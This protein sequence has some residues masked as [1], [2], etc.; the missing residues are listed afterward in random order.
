MTKAKPK[1][2]TT[3]KTKAKPKSKRPTRTRLNQTIIPPSNRLVRADITPEMRQ[4][5]FEL[6]SND[7]SLRAMAQELGTNKVSL[8]DWFG[9]E[10]EAGYKEVMA[11]ALSHLWRHIESGNWDSLRF[12]LC[13][14]GNTISDGEWSEKKDEEFIKEVEQAVKNV[15][16]PTLSL[17][18]WKSEVSKQKSKSQKTG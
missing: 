3:A 11:K 7:W 1:S 9:D 17:G 15:L 10:I 12:W 5:V 13:R 14:K 4:K 18:E 2:K 8:K 16:V 6:A